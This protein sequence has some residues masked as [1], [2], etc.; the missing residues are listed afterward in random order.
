MAYLKCPSCAQL[1]HVSTDYVAVIHCPRCRALHKDVRLLPL[2]EA[3]EPQIAPLP[4][5]QPGER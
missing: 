3:A 1:A 2:D 4:S 5:L